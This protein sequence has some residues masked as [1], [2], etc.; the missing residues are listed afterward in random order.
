MLAL[1]FCEM[2]AARRRAGT[3]QR[4]ARC[5]SLFQLHIVA[6]GRD[7]DV[8]IGDGSFVF[9]VPTLGKGVN[10]VIVERALAVM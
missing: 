4:D 5:T 6:V 8:Q 10:E 3:S 2:R 1:A 9:H 7:V